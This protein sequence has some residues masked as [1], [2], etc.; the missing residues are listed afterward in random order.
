MPITLS[1]PRTVVLQEDEVT[2]A[3]TETF[4]TGV[5]AI[6]HPQRGG[7]WSLDVTLDGGGSGTMAIE[8]RGGNY[9]DADDLAVLEGVDASDLPDVSASAIASGKRVII[10]LENQNTNFGQVILTASGGSVTVSKA[11]LRYG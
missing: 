8:L 3:D 9:R 5:F 2:V 1:D 4:D 11:V 6:E 7:A 10:N